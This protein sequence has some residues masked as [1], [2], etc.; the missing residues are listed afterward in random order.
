MIP[1]LEQL[2]AGFVDESQEIYERV[3]RSLMELEKSPAQG[4][5]FDELA[6]GLHTLK[7]SAATLGLAELADFAHRMEDVVLP[8]RGSAQ[9]LPPPVSDAVLKSARRLDGPPS[10]PPPAKKD[11]PDRGEHRS[12]WSTR[13]ASGGASPVKSGTASRAAG[14]DG[15]RSATA[16]V[17]PPPSRRRRWRSARTLAAVRR[18][19]DARCREAPAAN[20]GTGREL[21]GSNARGGLR[22]SRGGAAPRE[23]ACAWRSAAG[24]GARRRPHPVAWGCSGRD[25]RRP[26]ALARRPP[27]ARLDGEEAAD[28][29][30]SMEEGLKAITTCPVRTDRAAPPRHLATVQGN[31]QGGRAVRGRGRSLARSTAF[32]RAARPA[33]PP[34]PQRGQSRPRV[35]RGA[36]GR[37]QAR[38]G[39]LASASSSRGTCSSSRSPTTARAS[40]RAVR[41]A[42][43]E[44]DGAR[45]GGGDAAG[46]AHRL[47]FRAGFSTR[48]EVSEIRPRRRPRRGAGPV[49]GARG[50]ARGRRARPARARASC[51]TLPADLA[52]RRSWW[53]AVGEHALGL[54]DGGGRAIAGA[55]RDRRASP[56]GRRCSWSIARAAPSDLG[57][58]LGLRQPAARE[59]Q[60]SWSCSRRAAHR[61]LGVDEVIGDDECDAPCRPRCAS[62]R[63]SRA[64]PRWRAAS[65][66]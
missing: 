63:R 22:C 36:R 25:G 61:R 31:R 18:P 39:A 50:A 6:R 46:A 33:R 56:R 43:V 62:S 12:C 3:T 58:L 16:A 40:T 60:P 11:L 13:Q 34:R 28:I 52:A 37:G 55:R 64:R 15:R 65:S 51:L 17:Q 7:G 38:E 24:D 45:R 57:A 41:Q 21:A 26:R 14:E 59:G 47:I 10:G 54:P 32:S 27:L 49:P 30:A 4:P 48:T 5:S 53:S 42:A 44:R 9:P 66:C 8:L 23:C 35:A 1:L 2:L 20:V 19:D 29:V